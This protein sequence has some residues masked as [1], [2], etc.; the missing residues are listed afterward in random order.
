MNTPPSLYKKLLW[1]SLFA[2]AMGFMESAVVIY[3]R[4]LFYP[5]GFNFP[6]NI[7]PEHLAT[8]EIFR[9]AATIIMLVGAGYL[10]GTNK[11]NRF[12]YFLIAFSLWDL[13]YYVF[14]Y[15]FLGWPQSLFTWDILFLIPFPWTGPVIAPCLVC[16][17]LFIHAISILYFDQKHPAKI[18]KGEL[19]LLIAGCVVMIWSF[20]WDYFM[21]IKSGSAQFFPGKE[22]LLK[23]LETYVPTSFNWLLFLT[24]LFISSAGAVLFIKRNSDLT[25]LKT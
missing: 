11:V 18:T 4:E 25:R 6:L 14:L 17:G 8:V 19:L 9:E 22:G 21:V 10:A 24:G 13:F 1:L 12:A 23:E 20:M 7:I 3:L 5:D 16:V 2:I 15:V